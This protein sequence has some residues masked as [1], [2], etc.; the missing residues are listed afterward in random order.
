MFKVSDNLFIGNDLDFKTASKQGGYSFVHCAKYP[1]W[2]DLPKTGEEIGAN[3]AHRHQE[4]FL[5][6]VDSDE[7][8]YFSMPLFEYAFLFID[9]ELGKGRK[10]LVHCNKGVSRSPSVV[11]AYMARK[12][13]LT[14]ETHLKCKKEFL[15]KYRYYAPSS[16][17]A[18]FMLLNWK[19]II[20]KNN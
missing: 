6:M 5:N 2:N 10:V 14:T 18:F 4:L 15:K 20:I 9:S 11:M 19:K 13:E 7:S 16:G 3:I 12:G 1:Y 8:H 17:V